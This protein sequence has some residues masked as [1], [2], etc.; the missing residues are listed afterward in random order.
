MGGASSALALS[1]A[2]ATAA[3]EE[4]SPAD[5]TAAVDARP[6]VA[7]PGPYVAHSPM[8]VDP[9]VTA[10]VGTQRYLTGSDWP[11]IQ[12]H[13]GWDR[14]IILLLPILLRPPSLTQS[15]SL[16]LSLSALGDGLVL[17]PE[18]CLKIMRETTG[19]L[20]KKIDELLATGKSS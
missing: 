4:P 5:P 11:G 10:Y 15:L 16:S 14:L 13:Q 18:E 20:D 12:P 1:A 8:V 17:E 2:A 3:P 7:A 6:A 9:C 19:G